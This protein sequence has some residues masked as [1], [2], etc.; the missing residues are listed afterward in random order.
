MQINGGIGDADLYVKKGTIPTKN[1]YD[2]RPFVG[3]NNE[4]CDVLLASTGRVYIKLI[5]YS[6]YSGVSLVA[7]NTVATP[8]DFPKTGLAATTGNWLQ[9]TY[10]AQTVTV[11]TAGGSG[12]ADLYTSKTV[13]PTANSYTCRPYKSGNNETC[14][15]QLGAGETVY[16]GL[17]A[18]SSFSGVTLSAQP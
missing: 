8:S 10:T 4:N 7:I 18:Y 5:G 1:A 16:I 12:D 2:C 13:Q 3:G 11:S 9:Y 17:K 15:L 6:A 14:S